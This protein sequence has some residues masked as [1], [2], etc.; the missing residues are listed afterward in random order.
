MKSLYESI[1]DDED[2]LISDTKKHIN[3][4]FTPFLQYVGK[5]LTKYRDELVQILH[6]LKLP[7]LKR[8]VWEYEYLVYPDF[9]VVRDAGSGGRGNSGWILII[10]INDAFKFVDNK[11]NDTI[12]VTIYK[13]YFNSNSLKS[14]LNKY[15]FNILSNHSDDESTMLGI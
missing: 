11:Y 3:N 2:I 8:S 12:T 7:K 14:F 13:N 6:E 4:P 15:K 5:D 10:K 9:I 1:L